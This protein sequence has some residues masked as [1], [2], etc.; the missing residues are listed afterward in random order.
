ML[1]PHITILAVKAFVKPIWLFVKPFYISTRFFF[2]ELVD[3]VMV[4]CGLMWSGV[5][6]SSAYGF[7]SLQ[8]V[9]H[10]V[11]TST[12]VL[13][14]ATAYMER[15]HVERTA[16]RTR[17]DFGHLVNTVRDRIIRDDPEA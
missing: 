10:S 8:G 5:Y 9:D 11:A 3:G 12:A 13:V 4:F 2:T 1:G 17:D 6:G 16:K 15:Q 7:M 14:G